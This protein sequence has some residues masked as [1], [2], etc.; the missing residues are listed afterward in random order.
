VLASPTEE[1]QADAVTTVLP[2]QLAPSL[3]DAVF[4]QVEESDTFPQEKADPFQVAPAKTDAPKEVRPTTRRSCEIRLK[5]AFFIIC[6]PKHLFVVCPKG[7][8]T[9]MKQI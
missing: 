8:S 3:T 2:L 5:V 7:K 9:D 4:P 6:I 1:D